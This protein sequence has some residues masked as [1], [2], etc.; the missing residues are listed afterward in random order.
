MSAF[1]LQVSATQAC[2]MKL[3]FSMCLLQ[4]LHCTDEAHIGRNRAHC[5]QLVLVGTMPTNAPMLFVPTKTKRFPIIATNSH[6]SLTKL[7]ELTAGPDKKTQGSPIVTSNQGP[8][9]LHSVSDELRSHS[10]RVNPHLSPS[11]QFFH[12]CR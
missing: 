8:S 4:C 11:C 6:F 1:V 3:T 9:D 12:L 10:R 7:E 2:G 5:L